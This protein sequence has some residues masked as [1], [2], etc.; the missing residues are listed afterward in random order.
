MLPEFDLFGLSIKT[1]GLCLGLSFIA[2]GLVLARQLKEAGKPVDWAY[3]MVFAAL[4]GGLVGSRLWWVFQNWDEASDD[5][6][7]NLF[8]GSGLV[9]YGG[10]LGGAVAVLIWAWR[11]GELSL[12]LLDM[13]APGLAIGYAGGRVGCQVSGDGDY[14]IPWDGPWAMAYPKGVVPTDV[15][16]HPTPIYETVVIGLLAM[17]LFRLR[18]KLAPG[19]V[20]ALYLL[21]AGLE[22]FLVEFIR[23]NTPDVLGLTIAQV[24]ALVMT[25]SGLIWLI[26]SREKPVPAPPPGYVHA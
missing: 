2:V 16:V 8:G 9:F 5:I 21:V 19:R 13:C 12:G 25:L 24:V 23:R 6:V 3:E 10:L 17:V 15:P 4:V 20:F 1:F 14:G 18:Y 7:G 11:K 26:A 22:R